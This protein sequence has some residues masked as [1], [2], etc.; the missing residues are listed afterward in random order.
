ML[1][2]FPIGAVG[3]K[4]IPFSFFMQYL[5]YKRKLADWF[6]MYLMSKLYS[7]FMHTENVFLGG[8]QLACVGVAHLRSSV[9]QKE[10]L[11]CCSCQ[12]A[13]VVAIAEVLVCSSTGSLTKSGF[14][15]ERPEVAMPLGL[16]PLPPSGS[17]RVHSIQ[18]ASHI[19]I[20]PRSQTHSTHLFPIAFSAESNFQD[21]KMLSEQLKHCKELHLPETEKVHVFLFLVNCSA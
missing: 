14:L 10:T 6:R 13:V 20:Q 17:P 18:A 7:P 16:E 5:P 12:M 4:Y 11:S 19:S 3:H 1:S 8:F 21:K 2:Q 9:P 15:A